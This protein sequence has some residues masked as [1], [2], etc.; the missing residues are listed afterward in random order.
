MTLSFVLFHVGLAFC[1]CVA[2]CVFCSLVVLK[3]SVTSNSPSPFVSLRGFSI[4][5]V[6]HLSS[7]KHKGD[8]ASLCPIFSLDGGHLSCGPVHKKHLRYPKCR[9]CTPK[10]LPRCLSAR[11]ARQ[12]GSLAN[13][14]SSAPHLAYTCLANEVSAP[15]L[16]QHLAYTCLHLS[17][18]PL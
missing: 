4:Q 8:Q 7:R 9:H 3:L 15:H 17:L 1:F 18:V 14:V 12:S 5:P 16:S 2:A 6:Y 10:V 11:S 13:K